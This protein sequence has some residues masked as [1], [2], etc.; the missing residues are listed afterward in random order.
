MTYQKIEEE[1]YRKAL[2][3]FRL[4][5]NSIMS[6]FRV[7]GMS[8]DVDEATEE[9]IKLTEQFGMRVR[10]KDVPIQ[11]RQTPRRRPTE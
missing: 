6:C 3:Q 7:Y 2:G 1:K 9:I 4:G 11:V 8:G 5:L 10:G